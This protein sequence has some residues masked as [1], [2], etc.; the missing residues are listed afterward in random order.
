MEWAD[1]QMFVPAVSLFHDVI[2]E[3]GTSSRPRLYP[4]DKNI[5][6]NYN[7]VK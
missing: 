1:F 5:Q 6:R 3:N 7:E 4:Y 2:Y